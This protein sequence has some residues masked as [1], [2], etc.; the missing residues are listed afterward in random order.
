MLSIP[1]WCFSLELEVRCI[2]PTV[3]CLGVISLP[4]YSVFVIMLVFSH[5]LASSQSSLKE[6]VFRG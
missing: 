4:S 1:P 5:S 2:K 3:S 6:L